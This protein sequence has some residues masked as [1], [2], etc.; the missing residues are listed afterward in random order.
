VCISVA[1]E[2]LALLVLAEADVIGGAAARGGKGGQAGKPG[3]GAKGGSSGRG[4]FAGRGGP[5]SRDPPGPAGATGFH[6]NPGDF[7]ADGKGGS[8]GSEGS[9][10]SD[11]PA[12]M[13]GRVEYRIL[14]PSGAVV[15]ASGDRFNAALLSYEIVDDN[16]DGV[17]EPGS[18][19]LIRDVWIA[20]NGGLPLPAG[21]A[22]WFPDTATARWLDPA[23]G[24]G[25]HLLPALPVGGRILVGGAE[26]VFRFQIPDVAAPSA[27][28]PVRAAT[29]TAASVACL[30]RSFLESELATGAVAVQWPVQVAA[31]QATTFL[32]PGEATAI[33]VRINNISSRGYGAEPM[34]RVAVRLRLH[35]LMAVLPSPDGAYAIAPDGSAV[36]EFHC[37]PPQTEVSVAFQVVM[38]AAAGTSLLLELDWIR[39][40]AESERGDRWDCD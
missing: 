28:A 15:A 31:V 5:A 21:C 39:S 30:S 14:S 13:D 4:G 19:F 7:G 34:G 17:F 9:Q 6:G 29:A 32:A 37:V 24:L 8:E 20:N 36:R 2:D 12:G 16:E 11:A 26:R 3:T 23:A 10:G 38:T 22:L 33:V 25:P 35:P 1:E 27:G 18:T 40:G